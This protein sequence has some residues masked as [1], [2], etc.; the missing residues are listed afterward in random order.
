M[1]A[2]VITAL[3]R[4]AVPARQVLAWNVMSNYLKVLTASNSWPARLSA[5]CCV[6]R[7]L[8]STRSAAFTVRPHC[9]QY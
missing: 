5:A 2:R 6:R 1:A 4:A 3:A 8:S 9:S 7:S